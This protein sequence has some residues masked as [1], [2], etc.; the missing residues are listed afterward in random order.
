MEN[1]VVKKMNK[2]K[3]ISLFLL[4]ICISELAAQKCTFISNVNCKCIPSGGSGLIVKCQDMETFPTFT[5]YKRAIDE[6]HITGTYPEIPKD[7]FLPLSGDLALLFLERTGDHLIPLTID[8]DA[9]KMGGNG[10][11]F[12]ITFTYFRTMSAVPTV[13]LSNVNKL[14]ALEITV[15][16]ITNL[17]DDSFQ[18]TKLLDISLN[19]ASVTTVS[20][21]AF[22]GLE[23]SLGQLALNYNPLAYIPADALQFLYL[24]TLILRYNQISEIADYAFSTQYYESVELSGNPL[25]TLSD[26]AF[27]NTTIYEL[28]LTACQF[29]S[30]PA[31]GLEPLNES[32]MNLNLAYNK[33]EQVLAGTYS[34]LRNVQDPG[35]EGNPIT[36]IE[37]GAFY[38]MIGSKNFEL[39]H[40]ELLQS[41]DL[42][43][44]DGVN[45]ATQFQL[46]FCPKLQNITMSDADKISPFLVVIQIDQGTDVHF[47]DPNIGNW[48]KKSTNNILYIDGNVNFVCTPDIAWMGYYV[49]CPFR[50]QIDIDK[51]YCATTKTS[52]KSYLR[53][54]FDVTSCDS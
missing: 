5:D 4:L 23:R 16:N 1:H 44:I 21:N 13:A 15:A 18:G 53:S 30:V 36:Y 19:N 20:T 43:I 48:L 9:L 31:R 7:A 46:S 42:N 6:M 52:L 54:I 3:N 38:G 22:R 41:V 11:I 25:Q 45:E 12:G 50:S 35:L 40:L 32:L 51:T 26:K 29:T 10:T 24:E 39:D 8:D 14:F 49:F 34:N 27:A 17:A 47:L 33:I 28:D 37:P 2:L